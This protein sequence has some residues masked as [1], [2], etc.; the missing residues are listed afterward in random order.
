[1]NEL[2]VRGKLEQVCPS[3]GVREAAGAYCTACGT[4][5]GAP[6]W[7]KGSITDAQ[8]EARAAAAQRRAE[9]ASRTTRSAEA[10]P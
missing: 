8:R 2:L 6:L 3:C 1:M 4:T 10:Q 7:R 5:T 9:N